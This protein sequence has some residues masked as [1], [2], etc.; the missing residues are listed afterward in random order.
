MINP[1]LGDELT[2]ILASLE[3]ATPQVLA[4]ATQMMREDAV[5][6]G[7]LQLFLLVLCLA[8][9]LWLWRW[10]PRDAGRER[11][12]QAPDELRAVAWVALF[13][14]VIVALILAVNIPEQ[15]VKFSNARYYAI[16]DLLARVKP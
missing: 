6:K 7:A 2:R 8:S 4:L 1:D 10:F 13:A 9:A 12:E 16:A 14:F 5:A 3:K 15:V 11:S